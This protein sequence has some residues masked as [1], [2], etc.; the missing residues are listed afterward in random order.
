MST[1]YDNSSEIQRTFGQKQPRRGPVRI[2]RPD[3][4]TQYVDRKRQAQQHHQH[5]DCL[6]KSGWGRQGTPSRREIRHLA[7]RLVPKLKTNIDILPALKDW[8]YHNPGP[9]RD[10]RT[11][12]ES[13]CVDSRGFSPGES[14]SI[15]LTSG[16][17][18]VIAATAS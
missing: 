2:R 11:G 18:L 8:D 15:K 1:N 9:F 17:V 10:L 6:Y 12:E 14:N 3:G 13:V 16:R 7:A 5:R 4:S